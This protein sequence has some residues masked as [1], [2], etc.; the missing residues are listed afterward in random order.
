MIKPDYDIFI[1][2]RRG[3]GLYLAKKYSNESR[4]FRI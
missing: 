4:K 3:S 1:S 2:Y